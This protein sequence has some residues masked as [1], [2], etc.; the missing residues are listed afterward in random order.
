[1]FP[2]IDA[3][4]CLNETKE[5]NIAS[6]LVQKSNKKA[7]LQSDAD[8]QLLICFTF[9]QNLKIFSLLLAGPEG[10]ECGDKF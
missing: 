2:F 8:E 4:T 7:F 9:K 1:L 6:I 3:A 5:H 10:R